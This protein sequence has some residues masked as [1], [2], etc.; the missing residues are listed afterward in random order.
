MRK[1]KFILLLLMFLSIN[2]PVYSEEV[3]NISA[4]EPSESTISTYPAFK[5]VQKDIWAY[6]SILELTNKY[7]ILAGYSDE[8]FKGEKAPT[9]YE[10][11]QLVARLAEKIE[12]A[13]IELS[14]MD[15]AAIRGLKAEFEDE[16]HTLTARIEKNEIKTNELETKHK[17]DVDAITSN[18]DEVKGRHFFSPELRYR[19]AFGE[20]TPRD[21]SYANTR[22]RLNSNTK[23]YKNTNAIMRLQ[24]ETA[25]ILKMSENG[26]ENPDAKLTLC[27]IKTGDLTSW[28]PE[29][30]GKF[31]VLGGIMPANRLY[32]VG[33]YTVNVDQRGFTDA[34]EAMSV[35]SN[36]L[37]AIAR[38]GTNGRR[39]AIGGE[40]FKKFSKYNGQVKAGV[41]RTGG[42]SLDGGAARSGRESTFFNAMAQMDIPIHKQPVQL[43]VSHF[44]SHDDNG[45]ARNTYS[46][47]GRLSTKFKGIGVFKI[48]GIGYGGTVPPRIIEGVGGKGFTLQFAYNP[49]I[50]AFGKLFGDPDK[51]T[52]DLPNY[53]P[54]KTEVAFSASHFKNGADITLNA[55]DLTFSRYITSNIFGRVTFSRA[56]PSWHGGRMATRNSILLETI[57]KI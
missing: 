45:F 5:D 26:H 48:A 50:K 10:L 4:Q 51:I 57:F 54:G 14:S 15:Q 38:E 9:R 34:N 8:T 20:Y 39:I 31:E 16:I 25:N 1:I 30:Y 27:Y 43:K 21:G 19:Y 44:Y 40:Y 29:K 36:Q 32:T 17:Q 49:T 24:V 2:I 18:L 11:A 46:V 6:K 41:I 56:N 47:G 53:V 37:S 55:L 35:Y 23:M 3:Q 52:H 12:A 42:G 13:Q 33:H 28:I 7:K 22:L